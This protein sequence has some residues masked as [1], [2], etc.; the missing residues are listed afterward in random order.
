LPKGKKAK[1]AARELDKGQEGGSNQEKK[2][3]LLQDFRNRGGHK[4]CLD[5]VRETDQEGNKGTR[6]GSRKC[7]RYTKCKLTC[8]V[9]R[10]REIWR[11]IREISGGGEKRVGTPDF[12]FSSKKGEN[13]EVGGI[14]G[15]RGKK[16]WISQQY[17]SKKVGIDVALWA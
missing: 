16:V 4:V 1:R 9:G 5:P 2:E 6:R 8:M 13:K 17:H 15:G 14:R 12:T 11:G 3:D 10:E 7:R